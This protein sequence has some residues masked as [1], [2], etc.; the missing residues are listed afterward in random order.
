VKPERWSELRERIEAAFTPPVRDFLRRLVRGVCVCGT[1]VFSS[2]AAWSVY[3]YPSDCLEPECE[4]AIGY[5]I[6]FGVLTVV[7]ALPLV[8]WAVDARNERAERKRGPS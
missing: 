4:Q 8:A 7:F 3:T 5:V 6:W 2:M 1:G